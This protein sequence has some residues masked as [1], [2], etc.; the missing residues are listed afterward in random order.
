LSSRPALKLF[1]GALLLYNL[2]CRPIS[3]GDTVTASLLPVQVVLHGR[4]DF[5]AF[6]PRLKQFYGGNAYFLYAKD[7]RYYSSYPVAQPL[8]LTPLYA[9][10]MLVPAARTLPVATEILVSRILEKLVASVIAAASV[11]FLFLL[12]R[13]ITSER[14]ALLL[15]VVYAF[16]TNTWSTSSQALWQHGASQLTIVVSLLCLER[17]LEDQSRWRAAAGAGLFAAL[18]TAMRPTDVLFFAASL[19]VVSW[20]ARRPS[21]L[22]SYA[23]FGALIGGSLALYNLRLFGNVRGWYTQSIDG[24]FWSGLVGLTVGPSHGLFV[25]SP[26]LLFSLAGAYFCRRAGSVPQRV[27]LPITL[28]FT[29][30]HVAFYSYWPIWWGG[31]CYGP[32]LL[33]DVLP[34][35]ILLLAAALGWVAR[36]RVL[37]A[38]FAATLVFSIGVQL[39]GVFCYPL[40]FRSPEPLWDWRHCPIVENARRG[41]ALAPHRVIAGWAGDLLHGRAPDTSHTGLLIR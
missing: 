4:L 36:H 37:K 22:A 30:S 28:L 21:L 7:G 8:L 2:N 12:L 16:A 24:A 17:F 20:R 1:L 41:V 10:L 11:A 31:D 27:L 40:G 32:R 23:G 9:P 29:V 15:A 34:C 5:N 13:R 35:L 14:R 18:S 3:S 38:A 39:V 26:V 25:Y 33:T 19:A 6:E